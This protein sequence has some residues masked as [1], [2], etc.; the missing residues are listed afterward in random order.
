[1]HLALRQTVS[2]ADVERAVA[3]GS[4]LAAALSREGRA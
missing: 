3:L 4:S 1:V 2:T